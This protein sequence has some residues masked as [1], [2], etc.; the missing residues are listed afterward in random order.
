[1]LKNKASIRT[2]QARTNRREVKTLVDVMVIL[3]SQ[4]KVATSILITATTTKAKVYPF[5]LSTRK[6]TRPSPNKISS[7]TINPRNNTSRLCPSNIYSRTRTSQLTQTWVS[8]PILWTILLFLALMQL[9]RKSLTPWQRLSRRLQSQC[10]TFQPRG[11]PMKRPK[12]LKLR[13]M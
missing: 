3:T 8:R 7:T 11:K 13:I 5:S 4:A 2:L 10:L 12:A 1:M 6:C 9:R